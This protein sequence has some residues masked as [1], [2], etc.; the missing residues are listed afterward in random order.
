MAV[1]CGHGFTLVVTE[2]GDMYS[3]GLNSSGQL[4][5][6][7]VTDDF[8]EPHL[9]SRESTFGGEEILMV[10]AAMTRGAAVTKQGSLFT[11]GTGQG[12]GHTG[13][14][15]MPMRL[16]KECFGNSHVIMVSCGDK[17]TIVL[18]ASGRVWTCGPTDH[19][20]P[21]Q[22][23][24]DKFCLIDP[25]RFDNRKIVMIASGSLH[26]MAVDED[27]ILWTW[28]DN[29]SGQLGVGYVD[30]DPDLDDFEDEG[31][32]IRDPVAIP[33]E[34]FDGNNVVHVAGSSH[35]TMLV[36]A[37]GSLWACGNGI[38]ESNAPLPLT[39]ENEYAPY[40]IAGSELFGGQGVRMTSCGPKHTLILG[41]DNRV[42]VCGIG[43]NNELGLGMNWQNAG[44]DHTHTVP[45]LIPDTAHFTNGN[46]MT[47]SAGTQ[48]SVA[49]MR[50]G[51]VYTWGRGSWHFRELALM[52]RNT[53]LGQ[54]ALG[55]NVRTPRQ[56]SPTL[57]HGEY[58]GH[59]HTWLSTHP[60]H[61]VA[62]A[63]GMHT[64]L[65]VDTPMT[66]VPD[67]VM[68]RVLTESMRFEP[69]YGVGLMALL[70]LHGS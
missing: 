36:M 25:V 3:F 66:G 16:G 69:Q 8:P 38:F 60:D 10:A 40:R 31:Y 49:V 37:D 34:T 9:I 64:R 46:V 62:F 58:I 14:V 59:W 54:G 47:V 48:H 44:F 32:G 20:Q 4:G 19:V 42:W 51:T 22:I 52:N 43:Y 28:G 41:K 68:H 2:N 18:T 50:D 1:A 13:A 33:P 23:H 35:C 63:M 15:G 53:G 70:G 26:T 57:F 30:A 56:L 65:G 29:F 17:S 67:E 21:R 45:T 5:V 6:S 12:L 61:T 11:W 39:N 27:G 7:L 55:Q 24:T